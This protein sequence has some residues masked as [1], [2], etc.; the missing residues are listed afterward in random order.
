MGIF[1]SDVTFDS[2]GGGG[3]GGGGGHTPLYKLYRVDLWVSFFL[4][5]ALVASV[6][7]ISK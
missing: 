3:G 4:I 6:L 5:T 1:G 2:G 7:V